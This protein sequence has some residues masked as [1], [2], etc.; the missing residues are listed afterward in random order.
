MARYIRSSHAALVLALF[1]TSAASAQ[2]VNQGGPPP[3][4]NASMTSAEIDSRLDAYF[5]KLAADDAFS[6]VALVAR[7]G[8][9]PLGVARGGPELVE[10]PVF[11]KA[12]GFADR[13]KKIPNHIRTR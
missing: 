5:A 1:I 2:V 6:G 8:V 10:G 9:P 3:P 12:Y 11:F 7:N 13:E 4:I